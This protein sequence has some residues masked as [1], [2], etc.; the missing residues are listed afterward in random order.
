MTSSLGDG[1][2]PLELE[3]MCAA[4]TPLAEQ[5]M[6]ASLNL[7]DGVSLVGVYGDSHPGNAR[8][9]GPG[10]PR[11]HTSWQDRRWGKLPPPVGR[12]RAPPP[13]L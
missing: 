8:G 7:T 4:R 3:A 1:R 10:L 2:C 12:P 13:F 11:P 6:F 9:E 5:P